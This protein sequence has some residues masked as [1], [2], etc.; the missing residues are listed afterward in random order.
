MSMG[1]TFLHVSE[2]RG[3][4][5][6][7]DALCNPH[8]QRTV[9]NVPSSHRSGFR[10][11]FGPG[12]GSF[13]A[14]VY[15]QFEKAVVRKHSPR[16]WRPEGAPRAVSEVSAQISKFSFFLGLWRFENQVLEQ[17]RG[18]HLSKYLFPF[19]EMLLISKSIQ[20]MIVQINFWNGKKWWKNLCWS[21]TP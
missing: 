6:L 9:R 20:K 14:R 8:I 15:I 17:F 2:H 7:L 5:F 1:D 3:T 4:S 16:R 13:Y 18:R 12:C 19:S 21:N 10:W 11:S